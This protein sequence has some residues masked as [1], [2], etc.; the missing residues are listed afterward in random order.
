M[1]EVPVFSSRVSLCFVCEGL[2]LA[3]GDSSLLLI[4]DSGM[5]GSL[6]SGLVESRT[7]WA[8]WQSCVIMVSTWP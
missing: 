8:L 4:W 2:A 1:L 3:D 5:L 6:P 7:I